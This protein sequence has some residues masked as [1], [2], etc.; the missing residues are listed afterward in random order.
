MRCSA[1][2]GACLEAPNLVRICLH[3]CVK[4]KFLD[5]LAPLLTDLDVSGCCVLHSLPLHSQSLC[6]L[7][8]ANITGCK[9][10]DEAF[11]GRLVNHCRHLRQLHVFGLGAT[12]KGGN[13]RGRQKIGKATL[14]K[15]TVGRPNLDLIVTKKDW[16]DLKAKRDCVASGHLEEDDTAAMATN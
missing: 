12:E 16:R 6:G 8:I 3:G 5:L 9:Q 1:L 13:G 2:T 10:L 15:L 14:A 11:L 7:R 4:L